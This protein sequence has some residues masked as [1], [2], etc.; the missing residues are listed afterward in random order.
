MK[1]FI[2]PVLMSCVLITG[3]DQVRTVYL[4]VNHDITLADSSSVD[5]TV[6]DVT[7]SRDSKGPSAKL[8]SA[9]YGLDDALPRFSDFAICEGA[10]GKDGMP[11]I[12]SHEVDFSTLQAGDF[13][14]K[15]RSGKTGEITCVTLAPADDEGEHRTVLI[16]GNYGS[17]DDQPAQVKVVGNVLSKDN[18]LNFKGIST[19]VT[20]LEEGPSLVLAETVPEQEWELGKLASPLPFGGGS[21]C[22]ESTKQVARVVW[23]GG[24]TKPGGDEIDELDWQHYKATIIQDSGHE[25]EVTPFALGDLG[26]GDNNHELCLDVEGVLKSVFF[27][28]GHLTDPREDLNPETKVDVSGSS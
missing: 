18:T 15:T 14:V 13:K 22:P 1:P 9:F 26:D 21:G 25:L 6:T 11:V 2:L 27:P 10:G 3:C 28:A 5:T 17:I 16:V 8:L 20:A 23:N 7:V 24:V 4:L 19:V 12:F